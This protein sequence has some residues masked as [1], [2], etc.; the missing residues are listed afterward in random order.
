M[1]E[2]VLLA[3]GLDESDAV[4]V[5][6]GQAQVAERLVVD[7]EEPAGG[8][9][10]RG[11]VPDRCPVRERQPREAVAEVL[12]ELPDDARL[13]QDL[14]HREYEVGCRCPLGKCPVEPE[15]DD[16]G[17]EHRDRLSQHRRLC[18]DPADAP[19]EHPEP[20][21]H[22]RVRVGADERVGERLA[23][24]LLDHTRQELQV[25]LVADAGIGWDGLEVRERTLTPAEKGVTLPVAAELE[26]RVP[27]DREAGGEVVDLDRV[28]DHELG[29]DQWVDF[30]RVTT[31]GCHRGAHRR[32]IDDGRHAREVLQ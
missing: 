24:P 4:V 27:L 7:G 2:A 9:V 17:D 14:G 26:R 28:V 25:D 20:V 22:R 31:E 23:V 16:L 12:D 18:L 15:A 29:R 11:H 30:L 32:E 10:L 3:V 5:A 1:P 21:D 13:A 6:P 8:A 19:A